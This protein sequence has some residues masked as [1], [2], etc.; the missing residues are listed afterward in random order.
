MADS[1]NFETDMYF[2]EHQSGGYSAF[3]VISCW[4]NRK[5]ENE[6]DSN[7]FMK[8]VILDIKNGADPSK[9]IYKTCQ[10][11]A[12]HLLNV[13]FHNFGTLFTLKQ[14]SSNFGKTWNFCVN[15]FN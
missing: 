1:Y 8:L 14:F 15:Q 12:F 2:C 11:G 13:S 5:F 10:A 4:N 7:L 6:A 3:Y 9:L